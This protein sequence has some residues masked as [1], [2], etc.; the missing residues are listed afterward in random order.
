MLVDM[1]PAVDELTPEERCET[2]LTDMDGNPVALFSSLNP[3]TVDRHIK[4]MADYNIDGFASQRFVIE[5]QSSRGLARRDLALKDQMDAAR[6]HGRAFYI[7]YDI[8]GADPASWAETI[9][10]DWDHLVQDFG[11]LSHP[12]YWYESGR[13]V[14]EIWGLGFTDRPGTPQE[15]L[16]LVR[17]FKTYRNG[18]TLI[19]GVPS[20]W[21][22][23]DGDSK[24]E[25]GWSAVYGELSIL[26]PWTVGRYVNQASFD[27]Y[28]KTIVEPD[29]ALLRQTRQ[30][31]LPVIWP[32][33][34]FRNGARD[35]SKFNK[36]PRL[37]G[38][39]YNMQLS[40]ISKPYVNMLYTAMFD[41]VDEGT[42]IFKVVPKK[43]ELPVGMEGVALDQDGCLLSS[44]AYL[45]L[46]RNASGIL[47]TS[48][49]MTST[50]SAR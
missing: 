6:K 11:I 33:F 15:T 19:G 13:P 48:G 3:E 49:I 29:L 27:S 37:C 40:V 16:A 17:Y 25:A 14:L 39:F 9:K 31:Y 22:Q 34:S 28:V 50:N 23:R 32:G 10:S 8:S 2:G 4:W 41:E 18:M 1:M 47:H 44:D 30:G 46:A 42:A 43:E 36:I 5:L 26:S 38:S 24:P 45:V 7:T 12:G 21:R 35:E 20:H